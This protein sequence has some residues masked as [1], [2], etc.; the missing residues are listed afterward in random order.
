MKLVVVQDFPAPPSRLWEV[1]SD[2]SYLGEKY[3]AL[4]AIHVDVQRFEAS[5]SSIEIVLT[6]RIPVDL[7]RIP[8]FARS[9]VGQ[10]QTME[11]RT[12]WRRDPQDEIDGKLIIT[13]VGRP[14]RIAGTA[15]L[16]PARE[17]RSR[18]TLE[19]DVTS[20]VPLIGGKIAKLFAE[21]V[22]AALQADHRFTLGYL[23]RAA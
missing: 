12:S 9:I 8:S 14:V 13:A 5:A 16:L 20:D 7:A 19:F 11:H 3:L 15:R 23:E 18:L 1:F 22:E 17:G 10:E 2:P 6:R 21:Q 4:G